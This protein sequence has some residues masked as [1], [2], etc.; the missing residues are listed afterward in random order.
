MAGSV[1]FRRPVSIIINEA[2]ISH[3]VYRPPSGPSSLTALL[4][5]SR[6]LAWLRFLVGRS[7]PICVLATL[8]ALALAAS[9]GGVVMLDRSRSLE[10]AELAARQVADLARQR[11]ADLLSRIDGALRLLGEQ[12][13]AIEHNDPTPPRPATAAQATAA[14]AGA[15]ASAPARLDALLAQRRRSET[16]ILGLY[17]VDASGLVLARSSATSFGLGALLPACLRDERIEPDLL[18]LRRLGAGPLGAAGAPDSGDSGSTG[19]VCAMRGLP[20]PGQAAASGATGATPAMGALPG[21][22]VVALLAPDLFTAEYADLA[23]GAHGLIALRDES[24]RLL[25]RLVADGGAPDGS[26][27]AAAEARRFG[28]DG[29]RA[30]SGSADGGITALRRID[31][32]VAAIIAVSLS[33]DDVLHDWWFRAMLTGGSLLTVVAFV[34]LALLAL[35]RFETREADRVERLAGMSAALQGIADAESLAARLVEQARSLVPCEAVSDPA[36]EAPIDPSGEARRALPVDALAG[37]GPAFRLSVLRHDLVRIGPAVLRSLNAAGF[38]P[39]DLAYL[40]MLAQIAETAQ[41]HAEAQRG[42]QTNAGRASQ[43]IR[44]LGS[45][46]EAILLEMSDARFTLDAEWRFTSS[47][48]AAARLF[49]EYPEDLLGRSIWTLFPELAGSAFESE[50]RRAARGG[51]QANFD[52]RWIRSDRRLHVR[53]FPQAPGSDAMRLAAPDADETAS[54]ASPGGLA[55]Y[56]QDQGD[57]PS[58]DDKLLHTDR[59]ESVGR[60]TGGIAHDFN[61]LLT[62]MLGNLEML[63]QELPEDGEIREMHEQIR[64]AAQNASR[65]THQ[66]LAF[67]R[68]Q[69]LSPSDVDIGRLISGLDGLLRRDLG[70]AIALEIACP[71]AL[72]TARV[73]AAQLEASLLHLVTNAREA[74]PDGGRLAIEAV[75]LAIRKPDIDAFGEIRP[76]NYVMVSVADS[77]RGIAREMLGQVFDPFFTTKP[78]GRGTGLGL[79]TVYGFVTQSGGHVRI[80]SEL[81]RGTTVRLYLPSPPPKGIDEI[82]GIDFRRSLGVSGGVSSGVSG[83]F[84]GGRGSG[85][86]ID[87]PRTGDF[88]ES[89]FTAGM[90]SGRRANATGRG[91]SRGGD[92]ADLPGGRETLLLVEDSDMVRD[93][94]RHVLEGLGY[95]VRAAADAAEALALL[96]GGLAPDLLLSDVLLP[97]GMNGL[98]LAEAAM[99]RQPQLPV[100]F[101]SGYT[102]NV[103]IHRHR[104]DPARN[105]LL[106]PFRRAS[107]AAMVRSRLDRAAQD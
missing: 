79:S 37:Q 5:R 76:G 53:V 15:E 20:V 95:T 41:H 70:S 16:R 35:G 58:A 71:A 39:S 69:P 33:R 107:M 6:G 7:C 9:A 18:T 65:L 36:V 10:A 29:L 50:V 57:R 89:L 100:L 88:P 42:L 14:Q 2:K 80:A 83:S 12:A 82:G 103:D 99:D 11:S 31:G 106:K 73:D 47:N 84:S 34:G 17:L 101:M 32:P 67:A 19:I 85:S 13:L 1:S 98:E 52:L 62:V 25:A 68:R 78:P 23:V 8:I 28:A 4:R 94:A 24:G 43:A 56:L 21:G 72:W 102:E 87:P 30:G 59:L 63:D 55:I 54:L 97:N 48:R 74:M 51:H 90:Q 77:G 26:T 75:N 22:A 66:L 81:G 3:P 105:L 38:T 86:R 104:L 45:L 92:R 40:R 96:D 64:R 46:Q 27:Q 60:L 44:L 91:G 93:Y 61:N 49:E